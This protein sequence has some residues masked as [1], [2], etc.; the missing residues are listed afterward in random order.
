MTSARTSRSRCSNGS[1]RHCACITAATSLLSRL[2]Q[3]LDVKTSGVDVS[4]QT[5]S[6]GNQQKVL[7]GRTL[8]RDPQVLVLCEPTAGVDIGRDTRSTTWL[9]NRSGRG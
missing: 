3:K 2:D 6:G 7:F 9:P 1:E 4:I 5:L 8:A